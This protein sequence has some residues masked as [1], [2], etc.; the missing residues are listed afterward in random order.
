MNDGTLRKIAVAA[1]A[2]LE[3]FGA[4]FY[5]KS[6]ALCENMSSDQCCLNLVPNPELLVSG[7]QYVAVIHSLR[8]FLQELDTPHRDPVDVIA[9]CFITV[10]IEPHRCFCLDFFVCLFWLVCDRAKQ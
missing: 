2:V 1:I 6:H 4:C 8:V 5:T 10:G 9:V 3:Q 7:K